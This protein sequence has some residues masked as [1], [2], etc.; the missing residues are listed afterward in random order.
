MN[1]GKIVELVISEIDLFVIDKVREL[2]GKCIPYV[3][4]VELSQRMGYADGYVGKVENFSSNAR[5]NIRKL[6]LIS[7]AFKLDTPQE[8]L[9]NK[10]IVNDLIFLKLEVNS[11]KND[12]VEFDKEGNVIKNYKILEMKILNE[13]EI[14]VHNSRIKKK[15]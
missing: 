1:G 10:T 15:S 9:P 8:L 13:D 3:S 7:N 6:N 14:K 4:Q 5:Y 12:K 2:R 11:K